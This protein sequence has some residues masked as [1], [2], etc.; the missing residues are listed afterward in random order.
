MAGKIMREMKL[1]TFL[2]LKYFMKLKYEP[3]QVKR[4]DQLPQIDLPTTSIRTI[5]AKVPAEEVNMS[6]DQVSRPSLSSDY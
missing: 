6:V 5:L 2:S 1:E 4:K 3:Y